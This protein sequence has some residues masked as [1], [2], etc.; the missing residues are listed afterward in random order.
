[1]SKQH[2]MVCGPSWEEVP[3][4]T[5]RQNP[6]MG[7]WT[8]VELPETMRGSFLYMATTVFSTGA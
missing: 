1:M 5:R 8:A 4:L 6:F 7:W 3:C 2:G